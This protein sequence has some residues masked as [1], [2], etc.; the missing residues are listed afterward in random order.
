MSVSHSVYAVY[1]VVVAPPRDWETL[2]RALAAQAHRPASG[3]PAD[4]R[5]QLFTVGDDEH[6]ILGAGYEQLG[7]NT[8]R[9]ALSLPV[10]AEWDNALLGHI[11]DLELTVRSGPVRSVLARRARP[12][13]RPRAVDH[14]P[15]LE[16]PQPLMEPHLCRSEGI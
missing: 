7:P 1:G 8:Y 16:A 12:E 3:N 15:P 5:V 11:R 10:S 14:V 9:A 13:L 4:V 6:T 2:E